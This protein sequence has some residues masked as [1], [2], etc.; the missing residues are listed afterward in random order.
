MSFH[1]LRILLYISSALIVS[2]GL[3]NFIAGPDMTFGF[4]HEISKPLLNNPNA[5]IIKATPMYEAEVRTLAPFLISYGALVF[6]AAKHLRTHLY[7]VPHL[8]AVIG[9]AGVGRMLSYVITG[10]I[11]P[12]FYVLLAAELGVPVLI[13]LI[14]KRVLTKL[15][16][17]DYP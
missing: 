2:V 12:L 11:Y 17:I 6:L 4:I 15:G 14:Y 5:N 8:L 10:N 9:L 16:Y 3:S 13:F 1:L 7:Y